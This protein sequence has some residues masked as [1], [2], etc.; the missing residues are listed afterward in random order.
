MSIR[1]ALAIALATAS[2]P[3]LAQPAPAQTSAAKSQ[4]IM[5]LL[6]LTS[7]LSEM[8]QSMT[9]NFEL[10]FSK[11]M[12]ADANFKALEARKPG[13]GNALNAAV[14]K[15]LARIVPGELTHLRSAMAEVYQQVLTERDLDDAIAFFRSP[16][17]ARMLA[18]MK[19]GGQRN[20]DDLR[21]G[22]QTGQGVT[23][24][25]NGTLAKAAAAG[26]EGM[27]AEDSKAIAE[28]GMKDASREMQAAMPQI[29]SIVARESEAIA[30]RLVEKIQ[31]VIGAAIQHHLA[32]S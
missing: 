1:F 12:T 21:D 18:R 15:E 9:H 13:L 25:L 26:I 22:G 32:G 8:Q 27:S 3:A 4:K 10:S 6:D 19:A 2:G 16:A 20:L 31:P 24:I 23:A 5:E 28:F 11:G 14:S 29:T 30:Q 17:G 7:P